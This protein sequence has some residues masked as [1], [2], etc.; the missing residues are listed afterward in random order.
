V[1]LASDAMMP[2]MD[3]VELMRRA[4]R[5][6]DGKVPFLFL[7]AKAD[8]QSRMDALDE[9]ALDYIKKPFDEIELR[10]KIDNLI[11]FKDGLAA[12][13]DSR[14][15]GAGQEARTALL[16]DGLTEREA[17][18]ALLLGRG[19]SRKEIAEELCIALATA[20][21]R[22]ENIYRKLGVQDRFQLFADYMGTST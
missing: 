3:G 8:E 15:P 20:K 17:E 13:P 7:T 18:V 12:W 4:N 5:S 22:V 11:A 2:G 21:R 6:K 19:C 1:E 10:R 9:G 14:P 16:A